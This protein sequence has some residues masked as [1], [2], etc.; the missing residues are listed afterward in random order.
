[1]EF[2]LNSEIDDIS[3]AWCLSCGRDGAFQIIGLVL[4]AAVVIAIG[5]G[6]ANHSVG[7]AVRIKVEG[8]MVVL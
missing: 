8:L 2:G 4:K 1:M 5:L 3:K 7:Q 6:S